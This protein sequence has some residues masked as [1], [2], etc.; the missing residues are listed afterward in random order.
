[1]HWLLLPVWHGPQQPVKNTQVEKRKFFRRRL[2][3]DE[4]ENKIFL[5]YKDIQMGSGAR[6]IYEVGLPN[7]WGNAPHI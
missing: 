5:I 4:K 2:Y 6:V 7:I 3:T 1:M